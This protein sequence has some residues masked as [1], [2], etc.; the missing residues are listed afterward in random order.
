MDI[1]VNE[2]TQRFYL[3]FEEWKPVT[4]HEIRVGKYRFCAIPLSQK[5]N[6][7]EVTSGSKIFDVPL[8]EQVLPLVDT[9]ENAMIFFYQLGNRIQRIIEKNPDFDKKLSVMKSYM[10]EKLGEMPPIEN[11]ETDWIFEEESNVKH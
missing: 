2:Q 8:Y 6:I 9:H 11:V 3:A 7:S 1:K 10:V 4:G 5:I